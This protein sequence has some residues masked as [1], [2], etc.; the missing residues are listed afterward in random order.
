MHSLDTFKFF[1]TLLLSSVLFSKNLFAANFSIPRDYCHTSRN[2]GII[3][4]KDLQS[5]QTHYLGSSFTTKFDDTSNSITLTKPDLYTIT[6]TTNSGINALTC[7]EDKNQRIIIAAGY[8]NGNIEIFEPV[9]DDR[10]TTVAVN[11]AAELAKEAVA[12]VAPAGSSLTFWAKKETKQTY[13]LKHLQTFNGPASILGIPFAPID[14]LCFSRSGKHIFTT[15]RVINTQTLKDGTD[16]V[17]YEDSP[18]NPQIRIIANYG[19]SKFHGGETICPKLVCGCKKNH[20]HI[21][22]TY[23]DER[24]EKHDVFLIGCS[25]E[26]EQPL[27]HA[28]HLYENGKQECKDISLSDAQENIQQI[29]SSP[30]VAVI[31]LSQTENIILYNVNTDTKSFIEIPAYGL[32]LGAGRLSFSFDNTLLTDGSALYEWSTQNEQSAKSPQAIKRLAP[33]A[34]GTFYRFCGNALIALSK[35]PTDKKD[36]VCFIATAYFKGE[37]ANAETAIALEDFK[38]AF[39]QETVNKKALE[40]LRVDAQAQ[41]EEED[42]NETDLEIE[43]AKKEESEKRN[44][45]FGVQPKAKIESSSSKALGAGAI[46]T[47]CQ[48]TRSKTSSS[49]SS[50][51]N[52]VHQETKVEQK[53]SKGALEA[54]QGDQEEKSL[55]EKSLHEALG[56]QGSLEQAAP[57]QDASKISSEEK[58]EHP[59]ALT[60][61]EQEEE[62]TIQGEADGQPGQANTQE[63]KKKKKKKGGK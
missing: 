23:Q 48:L 34:P 36:P 29:A 44:Q 9:L 40:K 38:D 63:G 20:V 11:K 17:G 12:Y 61:N 37:P 28:F 21:E 8:N 19:I 51:H 60:P 24:D 32:F 26:K 35:K 45:S 62:E 41:E 1:L 15:S 31:A 4:E 6:H 2:L 53:Q 22:A 18:F 49:T 55:L 14:A 27:L 33:P 16:A 43:E 50:P 42:L 30:T 46:A 59:E 7:F 57:T 13:Y 10:L 56:T 39:D 54:P 47:I 25:N 58:P 3:S 52:S 5:D